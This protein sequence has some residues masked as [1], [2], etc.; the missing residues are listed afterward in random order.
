LT[1]DSPPEGGTT[2]EAWLPGGR[3][4]EDEGERA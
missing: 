1:I 4:A 3:A 2:V